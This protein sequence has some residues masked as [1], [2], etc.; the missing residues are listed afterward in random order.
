MEDT[1]LKEEEVVWDKG[2]GSRRGEGVI[3]EVGGAGHGA[4]GFGVGEVSA[5]DEGS[6]D[7]AVAD[8]RSEVTETKARDALGKTQHFHPIPRA[9]PDRCGH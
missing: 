8:M 2:L 5:G 9:E 6:T 4:S 3:S 1:G 7:E